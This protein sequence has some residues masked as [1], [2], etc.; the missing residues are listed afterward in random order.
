MKKMIRV[1]VLI[2][3]LLI[4]VIPI[5]AVEKDGSGKPGAIIK[6]DKD[7]IEVAT[8]KGSLELLELQLEGKKRMKTG[9]LLR[10]F[11][12]DKGEVLGR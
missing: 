1:L 5:S 6:M 4:L 8:G 3:G 2:L 7:S 10:G 11:T 9:D 12:V